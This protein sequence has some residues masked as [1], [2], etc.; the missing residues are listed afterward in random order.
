MPAADGRSTPPPAFSAR[1]F[2]TTRCCTRP[3][4]GPRRLPPPRGHPSSAPGAAGSLG[5]LWPDICGDKPGCQP[6]CPST[7]RASRPGPEQTGDGHVLPTPTSAA[8][9][10]TSDSATYW[11]EPASSAWCARRITDSPTYPGPVSGGRILV[12]LL[13]WKLIGRPL[14]RSGGACIAPNRTKPRRLFT[15]YG[16]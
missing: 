14:T 7:A 2:F 8:S 16:R 11:R 1:E 4:P 6:A 9:S 12:P 3:Q 5:L 15:V 10:P 13:R